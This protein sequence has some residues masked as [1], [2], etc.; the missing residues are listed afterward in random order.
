MATFFEIGNVIMTIKE[1][2]LSSSTSRPMRIALYSH[3]TCGLGHMR[4]NLL[5]AEALE[6]AFPKVNILMI[7]GAREVAA[8]RFPDGVDA[9]TLPSLYKEENDRYRSRSLRFDI[10]DLITMRSRLIRTSIEAFAPDL[11]IVDK[12]A[13]GTMN[14][15]DDTL[16]Y[17]R[18]QT[19][20][21]CILGLRDILD[22]PDI[23]QNEWQK[24]G[25]R[26][27][28]AKYYD[29]VWVYGDPNV[30]E[31]DRLYN[32]PAD[33]TDKLSYTGYLDPT[34]RLED[35]QLDNNTTTLLRDLGD[36]FFMCAV[37]G[38]QDG[39]H[40]A[41]SFAKAIFPEGVSGLIVTGPH[42][43]SACLE[44]LR[45]LARERPHLY[46][47][48]F[49][50]EP[51]LLYAAAERVVSMGG[52]NTTCELLVLHK[53]SLIMPR[54]EPREEQWIRAQRLHALGM[55]DVI[56]PR[57]VNPDAIT[58]W[59]G[60]TNNHAPPLDTIDMLGLNRIPGLVKQLMGDPTARPV[61]QL[62]FEPS[63]DKTEIEHATC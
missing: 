40:L 6:R 36:R 57:D 9:V 5:I 41:D 13:R 18:E 24:A 43:P 38:G 55:L 30:Y 26:E 47:I 62:I 63:A 49:S 19:N 21:R 10:N 25:S 32:F 14:E 2:A 3:D 28:I 11:F 59:F 8:F 4:R 37:G 61:K 39:Q 60:T 56:H 23:V 44:A 31:A 46:V 22:Q 51:M 29:A 35:A 54:V 27:T 33:T 17:I 12:V 58:A 53:K 15:L 7:T 16:V 42:M 52:Y 20:T 45:A 34:L 1:Q 48:E 50:A